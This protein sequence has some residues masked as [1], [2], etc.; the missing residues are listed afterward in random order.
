MGKTSTIDMSY[1][2]KEVWSASN[3]DASKHKIKNLRLVCRGARV[4]CPIISTNNLNLNESD[5]KMNVDCQF[6]RKTD[7]YSPEEQKNCMNSYSSTTSSVSNNKSPLNNR[8]LVPKEDKSEA[9]DYLTLIQEIQR[10][11]KFADISKELRQQNS[12]SHPSG[13][14]SRRDRLLGHVFQNNEIPGKSSSDNLKFNETEIDTKTDSLHKNP[15]E[16]D[17]TAYT[18]LRKRQKL[19]QLDSNSE[20]MQMV[21]LDSA[22]A[23]RREMQQLYGNHS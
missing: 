17:V 22:R 11:R 3:I 18:V 15:E 2:R 10:K 13:S 5:S 14:V 19:G 8:I 4:S 16:D 7:K 9:M 20:V 21:N 1:H 6:V 12:Q 23:R